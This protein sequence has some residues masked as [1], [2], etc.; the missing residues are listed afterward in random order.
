VRDE[1]VGRDPRQRLLHISGA[2]RCVRQT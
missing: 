1:W 2:A